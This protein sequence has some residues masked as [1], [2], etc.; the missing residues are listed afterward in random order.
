MTPADVAENLMPKSG[1]DDAETCLRRLM[2]ALEEA[3]EEEI[4]RKAEE[5]E[6]RKAEEEEKQKAEQ[7][8]KE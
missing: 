6:K 5:E 4:R 1:S 2:K 7:L 8:A 3:K